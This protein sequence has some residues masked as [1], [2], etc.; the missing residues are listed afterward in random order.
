MLVKLK[1]ECGYQ[2]TSKLESMFTDIKTSRDMM[3]EFK[4]HLQ[5]AEVQ[6]LEVDL[7]VQARMQSQL[8]IGSTVPGMKVYE[9]FVKGKPRENVEPHMA[10][11]SCSEIQN[12]AVCTTF[13]C[14][15]MPI[16]SCKDLPMQLRRLM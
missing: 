9:S 15:Y 1:T 2:F 7:S 13:Q 11:V 10:K 14:T 8:L 12:T 4:N 5:A 16:S 6:E 3:Q